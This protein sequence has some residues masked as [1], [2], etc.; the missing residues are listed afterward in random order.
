MPPARWAE[1]T[2]PEAERLAEGAVALLPVGAVEAH[3]PH[4]PLATDGVISGAMA[5]EAARRLESDGHRVALL[6]ALDFTAAPFAA[7]FAGTLSV[8]PE[9]VTALIADL[10]AALA[11]QDVA[12]L[13]IANAHLDPTHLGSLHAA[14]ERLRA[15]GAPRVAFPDLTRRPWATRLTEEFRSGAC[16]A[17]RFEGSVVLAARPD[18]VREEVRSGLE[19]NPRSLSEAIR[20]GL[21]TFE[22]AGGRRAYFGDPAA[23]TA[24]EGRET[25]AE[26]G[27]ILHEAVEA[28]LAELAAAE[29]PDA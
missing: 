22:E 13:A 5:E 1:L 27:A 12:V 29:P 28:E 26:L 19:P 11:R 7:G 18:L 14:V 3:G 25:I 4:L 2:Y 8:R 10:G 24:D 23:A 16:H 17:G 20:E 6:P 9:T 15:A 21:A